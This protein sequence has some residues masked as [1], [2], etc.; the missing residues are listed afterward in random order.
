VRHGWI[1]GLLVVAPFMIHAQ[2]LEPATQAEVQRIDSVAADLDLKLVLV[3]ALA[4]DLGWHRNHLMLIR[5]T[6]GQSY[7]A[8]YVSELRASGLADGIVLERLRATARAVESG[9]R[10]RA[11][12][13]RIGIAFSTG[14]DQN[15]AGTLYSAIPEISL[16]FRRVSVSLGA[17]YYR[18]YGATSVNSGMG[19]IQ[20]N[21]VINSRV[22][23]LDLIPAV[24]VGIPTGDKTKGLG[25]GK[26]TFDISGTL[27]KRWDQITPWG[28][29]G[30]ANSV[31][32]NVGYR[33]PYISAGNAAHFSGGV[34]FGIRRRVNFG[35]AF[36]A[37]RA[38]GPQTIYSDMIPEGVSSSEGAP[39]PSG[40]MGQMGPAMT[41]SGS[42]ANMPNGPGR[43]YEHAQRTSVSANEVDDHGASAWVSVPIRSSLVF[44]TTLARSVPLQL[45]TVRV[46]IRFDV[47]AVFKLR[48]R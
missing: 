25:T 44:T 19:D 45:T 32:N 13:T 34:D 7:G 18:A 21:T 29:A 4:Q 11:K 14:V 38:F 40:G 42:S 30:F 23:G 39:S 16:N 33:R 9:F 27:A 1:A 24:A 36:F 3:G 43:F 12:R 2:S 35:F 8:I 37:L 22:G 48:V 28:T 47:G 46:G 17:P 31:F 6:T 5:R 41:T 10:A 20:V 15:G 26:G